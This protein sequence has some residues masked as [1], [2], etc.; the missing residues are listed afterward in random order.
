M[1]MELLTRYGDQPL[2]ANDPRHAWEAGAAFNPNVLFDDGLWRM[3]YRATPVDGSK[4][5]FKLGQYMSSAGYAI[6]YDGI[7]FQRFAAPLLT[8]DRPEEAGMGL[9]DNRAQKIE[10]TYYIHSTAVGEK[11][12]QAVVRIAVAS[13]PDFQ[14]WTKHGIV[15]PDVPSKA[16]ALFPRA[17]NGKYHLLYA[18]NPD[19]KGSSI[20]HVVYDTKAD[21]TNPPKELMEENVRNYDQHVVFR[22][23]DGARRGPE[24]GAPPIETDKGW[25]MIYCPENMTNHDEWTI[26]AALLDKTEPRRVLAKTRE[27]LLR[28]QRGYEINGPVCKNAVFPMGAVI[29]DNTLFVYHGSGDNGVCLSTGYLDEVMD[30]MEAV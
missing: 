10:G 6:S 13:S 12:G 25:L 9:E 4:G 7:N 19:H 11:N 14:T 22:P 29:F 30:N 26:G 17:I 24:V 27:P 15:G 18:L 28:A 21:I 20:M 5:S 23:I 8:F 16:A 3:V 1:S 2:F